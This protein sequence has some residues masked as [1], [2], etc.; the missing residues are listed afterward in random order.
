MDETGLITDQGS[1]KVVA[2]EGQKQIGRITSSERGTLVTLV[3]AIN[4][5]GNSIRPFLIFP[6]EHFKAH[7]YG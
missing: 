5:I 1:S 2:T 3:G 7:I 6:R 4:A